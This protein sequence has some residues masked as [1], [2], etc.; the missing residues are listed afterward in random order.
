MRVRHALRAVARMG[1]MTGVMAGVLVAGSGCSSP[2]AILDAATTVAEDRSMKRVRDDVAIKIDINAKMLARK[3]RDL[4]LEVS[5]NVYE[6]K[7]MLTGTVKTAGERRRATLLAAEVEGVKHIFNELQVAEGSIEGT[8]SDLWI[9]TKLKARLVT[10]RQVRSINYRWRAVNGV[11]YFIG[12]ARSRAEL[13]R[14]IEI[15]RDTRGV[16]KVVTHVRLR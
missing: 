14:V 13:V 4:F 11:V 7:V 10:E 12:A 5:T 16:N 6:G 2:T 8:A 9:E 15:A 3:Y 1:V